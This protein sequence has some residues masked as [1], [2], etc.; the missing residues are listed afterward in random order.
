MLRFKKGFTLTE[1]IISMVILSLVVAGMASVFVAGKRY[2]LH[3]RERVA[4]M[5]VAKCYFS[6][7][8]TQ[9]RADEWGDNCVSAG[10][11]TDCPGPINNFDPEFKVTE[12]D[13]LQ[14]VTLTIKWEEE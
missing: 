5:E 14:Q 3:S 4:A 13:G 6:E 2:V 10:S 7:L 12:V 8:H 9:V 11:T 1:I